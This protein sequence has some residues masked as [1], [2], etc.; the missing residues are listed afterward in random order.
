MKLKT[1]VETSLLEIITGVD[2]AQKSLSNPQKQGSVA[3][4]IKSGGDSSIMLSDRGIP[5]H[6]IDFDVL[7]HVEEGTASEGG[8]GIV[9]G[10]IGLGSKGKSTN[11]ATQDS[12]IRFSVPVTFPVFLDDT[13]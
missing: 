2:K 12:R 9:V 1:F 8:I 6:A 7:V 10:A 5:V 13:K 11:S 4:P 3:P